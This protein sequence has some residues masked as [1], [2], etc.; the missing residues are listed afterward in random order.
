MNKY[1]TKC[2]QLLHSSNAITSDPLEVNENTDTLMELQILFYTKIDLSSIHD[3]A[4]SARLKNGTTWLASKA[5]K[6][7]FTNL[8][9]RFFYGTSAVN[10]MIFRRV[11]FYSSF[12]CWCDHC[13][14]LYN[15]CIIT[16]H[17]GVQKRCSVADQSK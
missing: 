5:S 10:G 2:K 11:T 4:C 16:S 6:V 17:R 14:I 15:I 13:M 3:L 8:I 12:C 1:V 9:H 7:C